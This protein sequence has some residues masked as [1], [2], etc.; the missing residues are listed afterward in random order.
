MDGFG[1]E[2]NIV[3]LAGTNRPDV[4]DPA[5]LRPGRFDRHISIERPDIKGRVDIFKVHLNPIKL[6]SKEPSQVEKLARKL[7]ALTP[8]FSGADV[9]NVCNEAALIA[10]RSIAES[11]TTNH[12][13]KAI[14][15]VIGGLEKKTFVL[16]PEEK[17]IVAYH[18]AGHAVCGWYLEHAHPLLK[19]SIIPRGGGALG[20]AQYLPRE[21]KL[22]STAQLLD[23]MCMTLGGRV[24][25][26]IF[27]KSITTGAQ[28]DLVKITKTAY[29]Q[30]TNYGMS[31][32]VG[33]ISFGE[34]SNR[35][36]LMKPYSESTG[37]IIDEEVKRIVDEAYKRTV[38]LITKHRGDVEKVAKMLLE[39][40][41]IGREDMISMLGERAFKEPGAYLD[42]LGGTVDSKVEES[43][44]G[45]VP[46]A[47]L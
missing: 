35:G 46:E 6:E 34:E 29:S 14:E 44:N 33:N 38:E 47:V 37:R 18:E 5:L 26:E 17:K 10:A 27:F 23:M 13:E 11:V 1:S 21:D 25:E 41:V 32:K 7:A 31:D 36:E 20:Y 4:L 8:G 42:Y 3:V 39:R 24:A 16:S 28:N 9:A 22:Q 19:V 40:E 12:F 30:V 45:V 2:G 15:R 43:G